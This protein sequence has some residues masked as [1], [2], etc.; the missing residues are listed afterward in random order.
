[1][2]ASL[3]WFDGT[4][5]GF[6]KTAADI[7]ILGE[8]YRKLR[9]GSS[10]STAQ[11]E[12]LLRM[13]QGSH[14]IAMDT[15]ANCYAKNENI[16]IALLCAVNSE[17]GYIEGKPPAKK[18]A[19]NLELAPAEKPTKKLAEKPAKSAE[20]PKKGSWLKKATAIGLGMAGYGL[21]YGSRYAQGAYSPGADVAISNGTVG[22]YSDNPY[23]RTSGDN[24]TWI[25]DKVSGRGNFTG[26]EGATLGSVAEAP[27]CQANT[28]YVT[29]LRENLLNVTTALEASQTKEANATAA[30][31]TATTA[32]ATARTDLAT[33]RKDLATATTNLATA[34][35]DLKTSQ[36]KEATATTDLATAEQAAKEARPILEAA[37]LQA[38]LR[39][40]SWTE[41]V[42]DMPS[43]V[44][45][46]LVVDAFKKLSIAFN[47]YDSIP[48]KDALSSAKLTSDSWL[49]STKDPSAVQAWR[50]TLRLQELDMRGSVKTNVF[51]SSED[52]TAWNEDIKLLMDTLPALRDNSEALLIMEQLKTALYIEPSGF[53]FV[54]GQRGMTA[55][56][57]K[58]VLTQLENRNTVLASMGGAKKSPHRRRRTTP[59][60]RYYAYM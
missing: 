15:L 51:G 2:S 55:D 34:T 31:G 49:A 37:E 52:T 39:S 3:P 35:T 53:G 17:T 18:P 54:G 38:K 7:T 47:L 14:Y 28:T 9:D 41:Q 5:K 30:A 50:N 36:T 13:L 46:Q 33:A 19:K 60:N 8:T 24:S 4:E 43:S 58:A 40:T 22:G 48:S 59:K 1:M 20:E 6:P 29:S 45:C 23:D 42:A 16:D 27:E 21:G 10:L 44:K 12:K 11:N 26:Q 32:L 57:I 25:G 56:N